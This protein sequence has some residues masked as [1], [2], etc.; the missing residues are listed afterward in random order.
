M[1]NKTLIEIAR[2]SGF[3]TW[4]NDIFSP[5]YEDTAINDLLEAFMDNIVRE[6][7]DIAQRHSTHAFDLCNNISEEI[8]Y[9]FNIN[10]R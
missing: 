9:H 1:D 5:Y 6:C 2:K 3:S 8:L 10:D 7:A 4:N